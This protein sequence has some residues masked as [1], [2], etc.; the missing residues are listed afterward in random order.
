LHFGG[1]QKL[2]DALGF[3]YAVPKAFYDLLFRA[4]LV[5]KLHT[6]L[7]FRRFTLLR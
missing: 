1:P 5:K 4:M 7:F 3:P 6:I 2:L